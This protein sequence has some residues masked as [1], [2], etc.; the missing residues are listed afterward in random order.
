MTALVASGH[1]LYDVLDRYPVD[2][3]PLLY[4]GAA[5]VASMNEVR[6]AVA[7]RMAQGASKNQFRDYVLQLSGQYAKK[8]IKKEQKKKL[9]SFF[10]KLDKAAAKAGEKYGDQFKHSSGQAPIR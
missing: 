2:M 1:S 5:K 3:I 8:D 6:T 9:G 7:S 10:E 4:D